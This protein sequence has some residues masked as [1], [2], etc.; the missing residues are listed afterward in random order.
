MNTKILRHTIYSLVDKIEDE[1]ALQQL[2]ENATQY[3]NK[4]EIWEEDELSIA[5]WA[6]IE[7]A[8]M[9]IRENEFK[10]YDEVKLHFA[11]WLTK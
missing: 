2:M 8:K 4:K 3:V 11:G 7:K 5:Q 10:T 6:N 1:S 9:Q